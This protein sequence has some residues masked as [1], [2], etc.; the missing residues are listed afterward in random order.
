MEVNPPSTLNSTFWRSFAKTVWEKNP[1]LIKNIQTPVTS[2]DESRIFELLVAYSDQCRKRKNSA[3]IKLFIDGQLQPEFNT[4]QMLPRKKDKSLLKYH[5]RMSQYFSDYCLVCDEL[6]Q[7]NKKTQNLV[8]DFTMDL[9]REIGLPNRFSE[10][11]LYLGNYKKTPFGVHVDGCGVFSFPIVGR[12]KF[13]LW[14]PAFVKKNPQLN[15]T[16]SYGRYKKDSVLLELGRGD[17][18]YWP[19]T[20]WHIAESTGEFSATWS[21]GVWLDRP[22]H[23]EFSEALAELLKDRL[24][25]KG[26]LATTPFDPLGEK[27]DPLPELYRQSIQ[28]LQNL[29]KKDLEQHFTRAWRRHSEKRGL[30][31]SSSAESS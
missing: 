14:K 1:Q 26:Q 7:V 29:S 25:K 24:G 27:L 12:K 10:M 11:G 22:H 17:M 20:A 5:D 21:I 19:S 16:F 6:L 9:Y 4:L 8:A 13:R 3:G 2:L 31:N 18:C 28:A 15:G 30:K 23:I